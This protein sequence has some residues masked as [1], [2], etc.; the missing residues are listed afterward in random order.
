MTGCGRYTVKSESP[1][2][3][4]C[5]CCGGTAKRKN[6]LPSGIFMWGQA[7]IPILIKL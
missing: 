6:T 2:E 1:N 7:A 3:N 5:K 4:E